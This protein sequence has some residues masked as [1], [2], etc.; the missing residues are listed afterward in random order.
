MDLGQLLD[1]ASSFFSRVDAAS[2]HAFCRSH[3][4]LRASLS[5]LDRE[6][7]LSFGPERLLSLPA[8]SSDE[9]SEPE[10]SLPSVFQ[11][12]EHILDSLLTSITVTA[13]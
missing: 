8:P 13:T 12:T 1:Q 5:V 6:R 9:D 7:S 2:L 11:V 10:F 3:P 4:T